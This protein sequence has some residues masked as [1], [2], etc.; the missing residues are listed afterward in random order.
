[1]YY[2]ENM[3]ETLDL[4][5]RVENK[6][7]IL[8][9]NFQK[10]VD[11]YGEDGSI[12]IRHKR[13]GDEYAYI[14]ASVSVSDN[15]IHWTVS[16]T[17]N[18]V[19]GF[20]EA[21]LWY[22]VDDVKK[23]SAVCNTEVKYSL[24]ETGTIPDPMQDWLDQFNDIK[25]EVQHDAQDASDSAGVAVAAAQTAKSYLQNA[26]VC[27]DDGEGNVTMYLAEVE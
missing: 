4:S 3:P 10:W 27:T 23:A 16:D 9:F 14:V 7:I 1:M 25:E 24:A 17:D 21:E 11:D 22:L 26:L 8:D 20:G 19:Q 15:V 18:A 2:V 12:Q 6:V 13:N 5:Y